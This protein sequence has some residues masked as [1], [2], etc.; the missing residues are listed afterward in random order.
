MEYEEILDENCRV[1]TARFEEV[2]VSE[3]G[4]ASIGPPLLTLKTGGEG[5]GKENSD[6]EE[7]KEVVVE[8]TETTAL[9]NGHYDNVRTMLY[10][11]KKLGEFL[12]ENKVYR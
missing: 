2:L 4:T 7:E 8:E 9:K 11:C 1:V 6:E 5:G 10:S 3:G 12:I